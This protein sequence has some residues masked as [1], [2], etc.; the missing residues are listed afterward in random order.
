MISS[1]PETHVAF[2]YLPNLDNR[3]IVFGY[4]A[5]RLDPESP[6]RFEIR[7]FFAEPNINDPNLKN[8]D[9]A[10]KFRLYVPLTDFRFFGNGNIFKNQR[11]VGYNR[12]EK[13]HRVA[14]IA[15]HGVTE[16]SFTP[17]G[18]DV[19]GRFG[20]EERFPDYALRDPHITVSHED[21]FIFVPPM[22][23]IRFF[24]SSFGNFSAKFINSFD[25]G[26][27]PLEVCETDQTGWVNNDTFQIAP[28][29]DY[30]DIA[31]AVQLALLMTNN[32]LMA[33]L[34]SLKK[35]CVS[36][37]NTSKTLTTLFPFPDG[38]VDIKFMGVERML[39]VDGQ[40]NQL[41]VICRRIISDNRSSK[42]KSLRIVLNQPG[43][44]AKNEGKGK[45]SILNTKSHG[46]L[47]SIRLKKG[48]VNKNKGN[49]VWGNL[50]GLMESFPKL[51]DVSL[52]V[53]RNNPQRKL[54]S[55]PSSSNTGK[56]VAGSS[57][58]NLG[59]VVTPSIMFK[60]PLLSRQLFGG[61]DY[62][63]GLKSQLFSLTLQKIPK[64]VDVGKSLQL[65]S[66]VN[67]TRF[68]ALFAS[69]ESEFEDP[70]GVPKLNR[71]RRL[72]LEL[73]MSW[74]GWASN[75]VK[76]GRFVG[77]AELSLDGYFYYGLEL[78]LLKKSENSAI[79]VIA[80]VNGR[81]LEAYDFGCIMSHCVSRVRLRG[82][83][84]KASESYIGIWPDDAEYIDVVGDRIIHTE[85]MKHSY[86]LRTKMRSI[87]TKYTG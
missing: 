3:I 34:V 12:A 11:H 59:P 21:K 22:E 17:Y 7:V 28:K 47:K 84:R 18:A 1:R 20:F 27:D 5:G 65:L 63:P 30:C 79:G 58:S 74:G 69:Q 37:Q 72:I 35:L 75:E 14:F 19:K 38:S 13:V 66:E 29:G 44:Y 82:K 33:M 76:R 70:A 46:P 78:E 39:F 56:H 26:A 60:Q 57:S 31:S 24:L 73:P 4:G 61:Q 71:E 42:F 25:Q 32:D 67:L 83:T 49:Y 51:S 48:D 8:F 6:G 80:E 41:G 64:Q 86:E 77:V 15:N 52:T 55:S 40:P 85:K 36:M 53:V 62:E 68:K 50:P 2:D 87:I 9:G 45:A 10:R 16:L 81:Q 54:H 43:T 23:P